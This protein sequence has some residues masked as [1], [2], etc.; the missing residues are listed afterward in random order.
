MNPDGPQKSELQINQ[1][2]NN[3]ERQR[4]SAGG[5]GGGILV[6]LGTIDFKNKE[7]ADESI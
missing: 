2:L 5:G 6:E 3:G 7:T 1:Y 4:E